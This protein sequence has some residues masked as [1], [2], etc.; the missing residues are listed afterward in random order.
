MILCTLGLLP[1][2]AQTSLLQ[3]QGA[4]AGEAGGNARTYGDHTRLA[5]QYQRMAKE[6]Q[7]KT[8]KQKELLQH[9]EEKAYLY[10][11]QAQDTQSRARALG[12]KYRREAEEAIKLA[13][14]HQK[15][16]SEIAKCD[17]AHLTETSHF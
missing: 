6:F 13:A 2:C 1:S 11:K 3:A 10:G 15:M 7:I 9:Y 5:E 12:R 8:A 4:D 16:A 17:P 14:F